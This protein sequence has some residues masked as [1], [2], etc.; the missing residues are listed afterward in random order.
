[1]RSREARHWEIAGTIKGCG[2]VEAETEVDSQYRANH[3]AIAASL[4]V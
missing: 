2:E 1:M 4:E 3:E